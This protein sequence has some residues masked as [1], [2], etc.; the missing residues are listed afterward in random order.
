M[1]VVRISKVR[2]SEYYFVS[3]SKLFPKAFL[4]KLNLQDLENDQTDH[5]NFYVKGRF[6]GKKAM[7][8]GVSY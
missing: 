1:P 6:R 5:R 2:I 4:E 3:V 7:C 8:L